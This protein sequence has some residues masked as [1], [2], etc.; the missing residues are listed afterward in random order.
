MELQPNKKKIL[1]SGRNIKY[2]L[3]IGSGVQPRYQPWF[4]V[5]N[6]GSLVKLVANILGSLVIFGQVSR[7]LV[8]RFSWKI[9]LSKTLFE[10]KCYGE[11]VSMVKTVHEQGRI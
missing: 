2:F 1:T 5:I 4:A 8:D 9:Q 10:F 6:L 3:F 7:L 11:A